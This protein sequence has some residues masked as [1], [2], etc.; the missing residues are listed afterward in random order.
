MWLKFS[1][2][3]RT[4]SGRSSDGIFRMVFEADLLPRTHWNIDLSYYRDDSRSI[5]LVTHTLL[6]QLHMYL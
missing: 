3:F 1:P 2:Q 6:A 4:V 5:D